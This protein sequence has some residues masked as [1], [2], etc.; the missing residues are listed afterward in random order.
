MISHQERLTNS[1]AETLRALVLGNLAGDGHLPSMDARFDC[2]SLPGF[3]QRNGSKTVARVD[4]PET[5]SCSVLSVRL[6]HSHPT[7]PQKRP[8]GRRESYV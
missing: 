3:A 7:V 2:Y 5:D 6:S 1:R 4:A 8:N